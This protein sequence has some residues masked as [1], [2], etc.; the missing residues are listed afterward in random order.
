[1]AVFEGP[2]KIA[3][4]ED[5]RSLGLDASTTAKIESLARENRM[6]Y[7]LWIEPAASFVELS[8]Q[9]YSRGYS[10][11]PLASMPMVDLPQGFAVNAS[12]LPGQKTMT[13]RKT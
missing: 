2:V 4:V 9:L 11:M 5:V 6:Y 12:A 7:E 8:E 3:R 1:M 13:R 10:R